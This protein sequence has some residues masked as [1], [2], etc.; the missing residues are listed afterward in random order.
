MPMTRPMSWKVGSQLHEPQ[1]RV[2]AERLRH[3]RKVVH[4]VLVG[5]HHALGVAG[6]SRGVLQEGQRVRADVG[7]GPRRRGVLVVRVG[8][9]RHHGGDGRPVRDAREVL[10]IGQDRR[11]F[12]VLDDPAR[13]I[14]LVRAAIEQRSRNR[15]N[16]GVLASEK[17]DRELQ[18]RRKLQQHAVTRTA[19]LLQS[20]GHCP[21]RQVEPAVRQRFALVHARRVTVEN[22]RLPLGSATG[23]RLEPAY[24]PSELGHISSLYSAQ[25]EG[26]SM[27]PHV[28][29]TPPGLGSASERGL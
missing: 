24:E 2:E 28:T 16:S 18:A 3:P 13:S 15:D 21:R 8:L 1:F 14:H 19:T 4:E 17:R 23:I 12:G 29:T 20:G 27:S 10:P 25:P 22:D 26:L 5:D 11:R 6:R 9:V 7:L